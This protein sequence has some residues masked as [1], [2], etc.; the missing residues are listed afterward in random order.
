MASE[1][2]KS[3]WGRDDKNNV[4][5]RTLF[6]W[7]ARFLRLAASVMFNRR[8]RDCLIAGC[9]CRPGDEIVV[10]GSDS[11]VCLHR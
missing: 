7:P 6:P 10:A 11:L 9:V 3:G 5:P 4:T 2:P 8:P 1:V